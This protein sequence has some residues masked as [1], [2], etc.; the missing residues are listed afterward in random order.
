MMATTS[1]DPYRA[2]Q[3]HLD[4]M[5]VRFPKTR[6]GVE[7]R[8]LKR[9]FSE[10]EARLAL[11]LDH[12]PRPAGEVLGRLDGDP[13]IDAAT[14][15][16]KLSGIARK[17]GIY[18]IRRDEISKFS[19]HPWVAGMYEIAGANEMS[20]GTVSR[21]LLDDCSEYTSPRFGIEMLAIEKR[22]FRTIP[23]EEALTPDH[24]VATYDQ[25]ASIIESS[26]KHG[27]LKC[28]CKEKKRLEGDPCHRTD[29]LHV[30]MAFNDYADLGIDEGFVKPVS[31]EEML[32][33]ARESEKEGLVLQPENTQRPNFICACCGD[34]C[35][36]LHLLTAMPRPA[37]FASSN[38]HAEVDLDSCT[39]CGVC[40]TRC[41]MDAVSVKDK[42]AAVKLARCIG[43]GACVPSCKPGAIRLA[44]ND[45]EQVPEQDLEAYMAYL[46]EHRLNGFQRASKFLKAMLKIPLK[47]K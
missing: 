3:R 37:D 2:L 29:R 8:I 6:S 24:P 5:P 28:I 25:L 44:N 7:I 4:T 20:Q 19:T 35:G 22:A 21:E 45:T 47:K 38:F 9:L 41:H 16:Q 43:C 32:E 15:E 40:E 42:K 12:V 27:I 11:G 1:K 13:G 46:D 26:E 39:G 34:C 30:C 10:E 33:I 31:K 23:I 18:M 36:L 17:G 14:L